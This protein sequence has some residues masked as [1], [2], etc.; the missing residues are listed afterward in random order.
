MHR[1]YEMSIVDTVQDKSLSPRENLLLSI[2]FEAL[3]SGGAFHAGDA[4]P[5]DVR[6]DVA[7]NTVTRYTVSLHHRLHQCS[8]TFAK[9][10]L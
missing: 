7:A 10:L 1:S 5:V 6:V 8:N 4:D 2:G 3:M 9:V